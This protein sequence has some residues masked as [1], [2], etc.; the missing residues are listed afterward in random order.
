MGDEKRWSG[1]LR[2]QFQYFSL[3]APAQYEDGSERLTGGEVH[4]V[5]VKTAES[6]DVRE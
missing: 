3:D 1:K 2:D 5:Q 6:A 4:L